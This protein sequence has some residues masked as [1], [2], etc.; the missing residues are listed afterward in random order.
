M[1]GIGYR[2]QSEPNTSAGLESGRP[3]APRSGDNTLPH[4]GTPD[5]GPQGRGAQELGPHFLLGKCTQTTPM[6]CTHIH[7]HSP[8][9]VHTHSQACTIYAHT[10]MCIHAATPAPLGPRG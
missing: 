7:G 3:R 6:L 8:M 9:C 4:A 1:R 2:Q 5:A 10:H